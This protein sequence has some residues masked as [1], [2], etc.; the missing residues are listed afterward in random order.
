MDKNQDVIY[1]EKT[2]DGYHQVLENKGDE[3]SKIDLEL[4]F[5]AVISDHHRIKELF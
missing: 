5:N 2:S 3:K 4:L 1:S